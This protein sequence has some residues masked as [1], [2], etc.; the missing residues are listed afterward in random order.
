VKIKKPIKKRNKP[1]RQRKYIYNCFTLT[2]ILVA[3]SI[4]GILASVALVS[5]GSYRSKARSA[6]LTAS[7][8][9]AVIQMQNCWTFANGDVKSSVTGNNIC[10]LGSSASQQSAASQYGKWPDLSQTGSDYFFVNTAD[11]NGATAIGCKIAFAP[12]D[13]KMSENKKNYFSFFNTALAVLMP[14]PDTACYT[15][16]NWYFTAYSDGAKVRICCNSTMKSCKA[17]DYATPCNA[18]VN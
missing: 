18:S 4:I 17:I 15:K 1:S 11:Q 7:L 5:I 14:V 16:T 9:S 6:K 13:S 2:E 3:I 8:S 10:Y 12:E